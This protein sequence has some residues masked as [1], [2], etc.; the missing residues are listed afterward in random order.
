MHD[1]FKL[2]ACSG[3]NHFL[4]IINL[5]ARYNAIETRNTP[6]RKESMANTETTFALISFGTIP[7]ELGFNDSSCPFG[8]LLR[9]ICN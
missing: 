2:N 3:K 4:Y 8:H 1:R 6:Y 7:I 9:R 5:K